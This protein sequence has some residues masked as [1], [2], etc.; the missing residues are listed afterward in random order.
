MKKSILLAFTLI[1]I[2]SVG[3]SMNNKQSETN[4]AD[5]SIEQPS[6]NM[7]KLINSKFKDVEKSF[8]SPYSST[9]YINTEDLKGKNIESLTMDDLR[10]SVT[11]LSTY[12]NNKKSDDY[13]HVYY[14]N[15]VVKDALTGEYNLKNSEKFNKDKFNNA[16]YK[17]D[18]YKGKGIICETDFSLN[19]AKDNLIGKTI[20][21]FENAYYVKSAN[22]IASTTNGT[23][24]LY[25]Y[26]LVPHEVYPSKEHKHPKYASNNDVK[27][28]TVNPVNNNISTTNKTDNKN[29]NEDY[30]SAVIVYT[31][32]DKI[33]SIEIVDNN[34]ILE[35]MDKTF[36]K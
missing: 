12:K 4:T 17:V 24:K 32:D 28:D 9:F 10:D 26:P 1:S 3:C 33:Q 34:F 5:K 16:E 30:N 18:F 36:T 20:K 35:L 23:D 6:N 15:G 2:L 25:F 22:F 11:I 27:L 19:Y 8:G 31:K 13:I 29:I 21:D 14:E 7:D